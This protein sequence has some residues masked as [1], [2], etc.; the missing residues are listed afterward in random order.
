MHALSGHVFPWRFDSIVHTSL[1]HE[2]RNLKP[3]GSI[4]FDKIWKEKTSVS[5]KKSMF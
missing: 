5:L 1:C 3:I 4:S 2:K